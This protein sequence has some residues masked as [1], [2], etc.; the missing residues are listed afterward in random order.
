M[1]TQGVTVIPSVTI[2]TRHSAD[3]K[4]KG[5][6][7]NRRCACL[8]SLRWFENGKT[9]WQ[10]TKQRTWAGAERAKREKEIALDPGHVPHVTT[11][12]TAPLG[13]AIKTY[14]LAK[15]GENIRKQTIRKLT[16]QLGCFE[17]FLAKRG[18]FL[19][20]QIT[21]E[22]L[23]EFRATWTTW[24][25]GT[26]RQKAQQNLRGFLRSYCA[27]AQQLKFLLDV[28]KP[29]KLSREDHV[30]LE[31]QPYTEAE[32]TK[33]IAQVPITFAGEPNK[34]AQMT[35]L[36]H[37]QIATGLAICDAVQLERTSIQDGWLRIRRQKTTRQVRQRLDPSLHR[38]LLT[39]ANS[40][41]RYVFW[42]GT[43]L[44]ES[45]VGSWQADLRPLMKAAGLYIKGNLSHR[46]RDTA[47]D[48]WLGAGW[49]LS[50]I[51]EALGDTVAV[52]ERHYK[53]L[54]S[55][56]TEERLAKLPVRSW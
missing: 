54:A 19:A 18:K 23:I 32:I 1:S 40:N 2:I 16:Y 3:C 55:K 29:I 50:D 4:H 37:C 17:T 13:D 33:L 30:R 52:V 41:P 5:D 48:F 42:N 21:R 24:E 28:L 11:E 43:S 38:E 51:A 15:K 6:P 25:S 44:P 34:I 49:S 39:V 31:P 8:R 12:P 53:S 9:R 56:R 7:V 45:A 36:I 26:T 47:V 14:L 27:D 35:A 10:A 22:D 46:F 20:H